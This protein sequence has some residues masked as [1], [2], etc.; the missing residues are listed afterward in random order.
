[1]N[2]MHDGND[3][4]S[5]Q[6]PY[7]WSGFLSMVGILLLMAASLVAVAAISKYVIKRIGQE[8][9]QEKQLP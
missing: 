3:S 5:P 7:D 8:Q 1:M 4:E 2:R 6:E 9:A